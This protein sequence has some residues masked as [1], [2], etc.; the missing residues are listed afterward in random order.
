MIRRP[1][2]IRRVRDLGCPPVRGRIFSTATFRRSFERLRLPTAAPV[3]GAAHRLADQSAPVQEHR[4]LGRLL[5]RRRC[6]P[7]AVRVPGRPRRWPG[8]RRPAAFGEEST[9]P[10]LRFGKTP[11]VVY[12]LRVAMRRRRAVAQ[13]GS[14]LDWGSRGR[15]FKSRQPDHRLQPGRLTQTG[16]GRASTPLRNRISRFSAEIP[17]H[18]R[19]IP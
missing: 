11:P 19:K 8:R 6:T 18:P 9:P 10:R 14:A 4:P 15:G 5:S 17:A 3:P 2:S 7:S 1:G 12:S 13:F 16:P